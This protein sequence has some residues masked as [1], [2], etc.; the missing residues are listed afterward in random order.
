[1]VAQKHTVFYFKSDNSRT[2]VL[3]NMYYLWAVLIRS[4][5]IYFSP[6]QAWAPEGLI[7][8]A[9]ASVKRRCD[10]WVH[11]SCS[12]HP[13]GFAVVAASLAWLLSTPPRLCINS[14][15]SRY[16]RK[17]GVL[18]VVETLR[19]LPTT[20]YLPLLTVKYYSETLRESGTNSSTE[21]ESEKIPVSGGTSRGR[22]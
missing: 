10:V 14:D 11:W 21:R 22:L 7:C 8:T 16:W 9:K 20:H 13:I 2:K 6:S 19:S 4:R 12:F 1:M 15:G 3:T 17:G 5:K 18:V